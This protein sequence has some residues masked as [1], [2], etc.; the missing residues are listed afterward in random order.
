MLLSDKMFLF[1]RT[2]FLLYKITRFEQ[3]YLISK[4]EIWICSLTTEYFGT[5]NLDIK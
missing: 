4:I 3:K 5:G 2:V 1:T